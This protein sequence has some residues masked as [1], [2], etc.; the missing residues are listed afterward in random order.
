MWIINYVVPGVSRVSIGLY[1][2]TATLFAALLL[3]TLSLAAHASGW[4]KTASLTTTRGAA[5]VVE[6][7]GRLYVIGG[8]DG[9]R[10]LNSSEYTVIQSDG[11][12]APWRKGSALKEERGFFGVAEHNGF[13]YAVG[14]GNGPNGHNLLRSVERAKLLA[15][16]SI[17]PWKSE[18]Q[19]LNQ[20][21]RCSKVIVIGEFLYAF[22]GFGGALLDTIERATIHPDGS[23]GA[24]E[25]L[26]E[27][28]TTPRYIHAMAHSETALY[29]IG[30]HAEQGGTGI[31]TTEFATFQPDG[32]F[33]KW[34]PSA[35]LTQ[36]RYGLSAMAHDGYLYT[37]GGL[38]GAT[39][40][41]TTERSRIGADGALG[42][43]QTIAP[44][45]A[46]F[47]DIAIIGYRDWVYLIGGTN[48]DGYYNS[49]FV[50]RVAELT[51]P[52]A[53]KSG[54]Q[55]AAPAPTPSKPVLMP[56]EGVVKES[57]DGGTYLYLEIDFGGGASEW[58]ATGKTD[59]K[60]GDRVRYSQ[61]IFME[62][63]HSKALQRTFKVI[64]FVGKVIREE[65]GK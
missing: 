23:L 56:N 26:P 2:K 31:A 39:F 54:T 22:G 57:I 53:A 44:L 19:K 37:F 33:A 42:P 49:V 55:P 16:G 48:R 64:R 62:N 60:M 18:P 7:N 38:D 12:L 52:A 5:G 27:R 21:R 34:A 20:P 25:L 58:L 1:M 17:G 11:T 32:K 10:F 36:G 3:A 6:V 15:D 28:F 65:P 9:W 40:Y 59:V 61:G 29:A 35:S 43:W 63:F 45:P 47:A 50:S 41:D 30:G 4:Q 46:P 24:W 51:E 8:V 14:G 13:L